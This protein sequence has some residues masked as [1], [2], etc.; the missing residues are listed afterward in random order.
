MIA[1]ID[2]DSI[3]YKYASIYQDTCIWEENDKGVIASIETDYDTALEEM[4]GFIE[5]IKDATDT[6]DVIIVLSPKKTF[7]YSVSDTYKGNRKPPKVPLELLT[8]LKE[9]LLDRG[10]LHFDNVEADDVCVSR[11]YQEPGKYV[12]CHIDK[13]LDQAIGKHFNYN[14]KEKYEVDQEAADYFFYEQVL[15]GDSVDGI[16]GC[17]KIGKV[18]AKKLLATGK[19]SEEWW[20]IVKEAYE[21]AGM[22]YDYMIQQARLVRMLRDFNEETQ[23]FTLWVPEGDKNGKMD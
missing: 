16:K 18:K 13:D 23:E 19:N 7:R 11:M 14:T 5:G 2:A 10:A 4:L 1:L 17:P 21:K 22:D 15:Q 20:S 8:K 3:V 6:E 12:L 9:V